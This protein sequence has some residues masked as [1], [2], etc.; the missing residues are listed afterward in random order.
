MS[1]SAIAVCSRQ[2]VL[3]SVDEADEEEWSE[4]YPLSLNRPAASLILALLSPLKTEAI[5]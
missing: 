1:R 5:H 2:R 3:V 4:R